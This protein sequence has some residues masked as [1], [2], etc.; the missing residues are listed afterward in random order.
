MRRWIET[1]ENTSDLIPGLQKFERRVETEDYRRLL[2]KQQS[3]ITSYFT[4]DCPLERVSQWTLVLWRLY[5]VCTS[6]IQMHTH[7]CTCTLFFRPL[8]KMHAFIWLNCLTVVLLFTFIHLVKYFTTILTCFVFVDITVIGSTLYKAQQ[9]SGID[10]TIDN[11]KDCRS[12]WKKTGFWQKIQFL[13]K[14][15]MFMQY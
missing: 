2:S 12:L 4:T 15:E 6:F 10:N 5:V 7:S 14:K 8:F 1:T 3:V 9:V 11:I 13:L